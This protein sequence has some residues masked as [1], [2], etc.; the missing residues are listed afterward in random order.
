MF[1]LGVITLT[2]TDQ[3]P[4]SPNEQ[5]PGAQLLEAALAGDADRVRQVLDLGADV[6]ATDDSGRQP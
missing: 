3:E 4:S 1:M 6:N 2:Q 5:L